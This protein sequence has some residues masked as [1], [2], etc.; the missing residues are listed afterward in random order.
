MRT[1]F[2]A[3]CCLALAACGSEAGQAPKTVAKKEKKPL[4]VGDTAPPLAITKWVAGTPVKA[5][6]PG[7]VYVVEFWATWCPP[8]IA[9]MPH[10]GGLQAE[11]KDKGLVVVGVTS[12]DGNGN[13]EEKVD[14]FV[15]K[16]GKRHGYAFAFCDDDAM[17]KAYMEAAGQDGIPCSF[18]VD[19]AGKLAFIGHPSELDGVIP[20]VLDGTW[21]GKAD[22]IALRNVDSAATEK[23]KEVMR[24]F[25]SN[26][27]ATLKGLTEFAKQYPIQARQDE[28]EVRVIAAE[29]KT[30]QFDEAKAGSEALIKSGTDRYNG[31]I[32]GFIASVW[33]AKDLNPD[34]K[35]LD[36][37]EKAVAA[38]LKV[39]GEDDVQAL[40]TAAQ[41]YQA[42]DQKEKA[43]GYME[44]A[45]KSADDP[46]LKDQLEAEA[47]KIRGK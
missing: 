29:M 31:E 28:F 30:K 15:A 13:T 2:A 14:K 44:K 34:R 3:A 19:K 27:A 18:V 36:L 37:A 7:K 41:T 40:V 1:A 43:L 5:F 39:E 16:R 21:K 20:K 25:D 4:S 38:I 33:T 17:E 26:P 24:T 22:I 6:E 8:C 12:K 9:S 11:Y 46:R 23:M 47:K 35:H 10:L 45:I 42:M 32:L